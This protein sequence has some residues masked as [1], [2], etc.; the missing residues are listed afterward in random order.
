MDYYQKM[1]CSED[2]DQYQQSP[3]PCEDGCQEKP[4]DE[5]LYYFFFLNKFRHC[6]MQN[7]MQ[8]QL[9]VFLIPMYNNQYFVFL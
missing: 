4:T 8:V 7:V 6:N 9:L 3:V 2:S 5:L 1:Y